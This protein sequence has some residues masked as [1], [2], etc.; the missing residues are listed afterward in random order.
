MNTLEIAADDHIERESPAKE[1][2]ICAR[3]KENITRSNPNQSKRKNAH[4]KPKPPST[5]STGESRT[6]SSKVNAMKRKLTLDK[7]ADT[8]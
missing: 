3:K 4:R 2:T 7:E 6:I 1:S 8:S 5:E